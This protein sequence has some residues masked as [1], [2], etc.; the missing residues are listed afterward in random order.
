VRLADTPPT[1]R[2]PPPRLGEH[3]AAVLAELGYSTVE[4]E[5]FRAAGHI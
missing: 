3:T 4:I 2:L 5:T 1:Y